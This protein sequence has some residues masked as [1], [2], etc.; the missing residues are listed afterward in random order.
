MDYRTWL[1]NNKLKHK[2]R[3]IPYEVVKYLS[4][5]IGIFVI[6]IYE[7][8]PQYLSDDRNFR[9]IQNAHNMET[10]YPITNHQNSAFSVKRF[11]SWKN[12]KNDKGP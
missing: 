2:Q 7:I 12:A 6:Y 4:L 11:K 8:M 3:L 10:V 1:E 9:P 5:E